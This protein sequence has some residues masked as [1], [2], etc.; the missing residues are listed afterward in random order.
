MKKKLYPVFLAVLIGCGFAFFLFSKVESKTINKK[1]TNAVA[2]QIGV[3]KDSENATKMQKN[4]GGVVFEDEGIFR[5]YYSVLNKD[6]NIEFMTNYLSK[7]GINYYLKQINLNNELLDKFYEYETLMM[8]T[9]EESKLSINEE[10]LN[11]Y[12]E[13]V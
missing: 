13:V 1:S 12:K 9:N 7:K 2:I 5:V 10:L 11:I 4:L 8:K 3:F 6:E